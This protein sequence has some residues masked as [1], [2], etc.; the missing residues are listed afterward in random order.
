MKLL[1]C[2]KRAFIVRKCIICDDAISYN[3]K[4]P[5]CDECHKYWVS[6]LDILCDKCGYESEYCTCASK[7]MLIGVDFV[8]FCIFYKSNSENP[9]NHIVYKLKEE[10][11]GEVF[12]FCADL[13][14]AKAKKMFAKRNLSFND[15][16]VVYPKRRK[17]AILKYGY[18]HG[19]EVARLFAKKLGLSYMDCFDNSG[20]KE[21][22]TL[23]RRERYANAKQSYSL[24]K[25]IDVKDK[26]FIIIDDVLTTG[27]TISA[28]STLLKEKGAKSVVAVCFAKDI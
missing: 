3:I 17:K 7:R 19:R 23:D 18:D 1:E 15:Y 14:A 4:L 6:T 26:K 2:L 9:V 16:I 12:N 10:Y 25:N 27:S 20:K 13:M 21:Q 22:K 8:T 5:I 24:K 11:I 28:C